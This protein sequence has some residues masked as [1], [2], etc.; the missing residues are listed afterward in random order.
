MLNEN[1]VKIIEAYIKA[2]AGRIRTRRIIG[3][4]SVAKNTLLIVA[5]GRIYSDVRNSDHVADVRGIPFDPRSLKVA[6]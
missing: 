6:S 1:L 3:S 4:E 2:G 5:T